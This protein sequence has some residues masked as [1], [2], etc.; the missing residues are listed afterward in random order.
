MARRGI[1]RA[2]IP[3]TLANMTRAAELL[4]KIP[5]AEFEPLEDRI[6]SLR[7]LA[8]VTKL[9]PTFAGKIRTPL[10]T[11]TVS[12]RICRSGER[13]MYIDGDCSVRRCMFTDEPPVWDVRRGPMDLDA[14]SEPVLCRDWCT[15]EFRR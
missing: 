6:P 2:L 14:L 13:Y 12:E 7:E 5:N 15:C 4:Q 1:R 3:C 11:R 9:D 10:K 8:A